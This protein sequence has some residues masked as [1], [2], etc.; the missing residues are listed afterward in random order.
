MSCFARSRAAIKRPSGIEILGKHLGSTL[1]L[2][3]GAEGTMISYARIP[4]SY[5]IVGGGGGGGSND[6]SGSYNA[7]GGG[8]GGGGV[9]E[10]T[11]ELFPGTTT[12]TV[13]L[14]ALKDLNGGN[15]TLVP[16]GG[17][18]AIT[19]LG[20]GAGGAGKANSSGKV[21]NA[22]PGNAGGCGGGGG[23]SIAKPI[24][25]S[26]PAVGGAAI[27]GQGFAGGSGDKVSY[28]TTLGGTQYGYGGSGGGAGGAGNRG[29]S[30]APSPGLGKT[31]TIRGT[32]EVFGAG[33]RSSTSAKSGTDGTGNGGDSS[34]KGGSGIVIVR[35][36]APQVFTGGTV[37][38]A[39]IDG[40][41]YVIHT[42]LTSGT[43]VR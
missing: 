41:N 31:V 39:A 36:V 12:I 25:E 28:N 40:T 8:G 15:S 33:G 38:T 9:L 43:L 14:G 37:T 19:A 29:G 16:A 27:S 24:N 20:G 5:V 4:V 13:G 2:E 35:Y 26:P 32:P 17:G 3:L 23:G 18:G 6:S 21:A 22:D 1:L 30:K 11:I 10:G 42:F 34:N 7:R